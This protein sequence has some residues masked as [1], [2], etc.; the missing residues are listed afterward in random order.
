MRWIIG[1]DKDIAGDNNQLNARSKYIKDVTNAEVSAWQYVQ[2]SCQNKFLF[3]I[4]N[5]GVD[6]TFIIAHINDI[7][8]LC[9]VSEV[10]KSKLII[11]NTCIL[12]K[13]NDKKLLYS[14]HYIF[15][16]DLRNSTI[17]NRFC[18]YSYKLF[19]CRTHYSTH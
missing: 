3:C 11:V 15:V 16:F 9:A 12:E 2:V 10:Q 6:G 8:F 4:S 18:N 5:D 1:F 14:M 13:M 7:L 19:F 17:L